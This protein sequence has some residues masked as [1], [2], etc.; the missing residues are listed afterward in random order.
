MLSSFSNRQLTK[1]W[2]HPY[3]KKS[4]FF[5][6]F[7]YC[8]QKGKAYTYLPVECQLLLLLKF[9]MK[10]LLIITLILLTLPMVYGW[11]YP[12]KEIEGSFCPEKE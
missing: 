1:I 3:K 7:F 2:P 5:T 10:K 11:S 6:S 8:F 9:L 12:L 4:D